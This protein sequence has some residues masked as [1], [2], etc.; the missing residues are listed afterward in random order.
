MVVPGDAGPES[1]SVRILHLQDGDVREAVTLLRSQLE[2]LRIV[3]L[4]ELRAVVVADALEK[5]DRAERLLRQRGA[6]AEAVVPHDPVPLAGPEREP[7]GGR[8]FRTEAM[9]TKTVA[10][11]LRTIY[12]MREITEHPVESSVEVRDTTPRLNAAES[13][14]RTLDVHLWAKD[15]GA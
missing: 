10:M 3:D 7:V 2:I 12:G 14:L 6:L 13:L 8:V 9:S 15:P 11:L 4:S 1:F 5:V